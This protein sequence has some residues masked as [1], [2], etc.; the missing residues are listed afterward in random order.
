M[1]EPFDPDRFLNHHEARIRRLITQAI[2][3]AIWKAILALFMIGCAIAFVHQN[4]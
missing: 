3:E 2:T 4:C 1:T